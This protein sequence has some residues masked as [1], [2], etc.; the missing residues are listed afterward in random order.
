MA[1]I[2]NSELVRLARVRQL[3]ASGE[4]ARIRKRSCLSASAAAGAVGVSHVSML[5]WEKGQR[6]PS[7][8]AALR[9]LELLDA[10]AQVAGE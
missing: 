7:G 5:R 4:A 1:R 6:L 10:L 3:A 8:D 2:R 9:Y